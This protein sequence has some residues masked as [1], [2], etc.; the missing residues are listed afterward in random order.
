MFNID[1]DSG[2]VS[3]KS[4]PNFENPADSDHNNVYLVQVQVSDGAN[5]V[6]QNIQVSVANVDETQ[7]IT[8]ANTINIA[9]NSSSVLN[10]TATDPEAHF[11]SFGITGGARASAHSG[12]DG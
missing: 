4:A 5:S 3:F 7:T 12:K 8:S 6:T 2:A 11:L 1:P 10:V 9:E